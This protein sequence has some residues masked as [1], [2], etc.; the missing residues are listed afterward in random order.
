M[1]YCGFS[2]RS[3]HG[4]AAQLSQTEMETRMEHA[5]YVNFD[6]LLLGVQHVWSLKLDVWVIRK[7]F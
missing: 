2:S 5:G 1:C 4:K 7:L 3:C 6:S